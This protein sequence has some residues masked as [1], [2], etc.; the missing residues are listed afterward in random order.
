MTNFRILATIAFIGFFSSRADA[1]T[2]NVVPTR[3]YGFT[4]GA[5]GGIP[6]SWLIQ[7]S[8]GNFYGTTSQ[9]GPNNTG[10]VFRLTLGVTNIVGT[11]TN[12]STVTTLY[13]FTGA[14]D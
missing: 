14:N 5:D 8:D 6:E 7:A 12:I 11:I 13:S 2:N 3:L 9:G 10:T 4:G 1:I